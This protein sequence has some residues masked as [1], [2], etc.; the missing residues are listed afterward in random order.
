MVLDNKYL[1]QF[2]SLSQFEKRTVRLISSL[3]D[4]PRQQK[5]SADI[6]RL[7]FGF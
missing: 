5:T 6:C 2:L 7:S 3:S 4:M 1:S